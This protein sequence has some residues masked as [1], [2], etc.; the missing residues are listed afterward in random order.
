MSVYYYV[1]YLSYPLMSIFVPICMLICLYIN[2]YK[3]LC[4][5]VYSDLLRFRPRTCIRIRSEFDTKMFESLIEHALM[6]KLRRLP[7]QCTMWVSDFYTFT[8]LFSKRSGYMRPH[9]TGFV[10]FLSFHS[11]ERSVKSLQLQCAFFPD[12][13][14]R[15]P[16]P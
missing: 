3:T 10:A 16:D 9:V 4:V 1:I 8:S 11:G 12:T 13:C 14:G 6:N 15:K 2:T 5:H 7:W